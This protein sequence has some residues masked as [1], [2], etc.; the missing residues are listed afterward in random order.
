MKL[1]KATPRDLEEIFLLFK[2]VQKA[3]EE[4]GNR[5]WSEGYPDKSDFADDL[6]HKDAYLVKKEG[7][8]LAY[9]ASD[10]DLAGSFF[11]A[12]R[13]AGKLAV[14]LKQIHAEEGDVILSL[15][16][17]MVDPSFQGQGIAHEIFAAL[18]GLYP[19]SILV[20]AVFPENTRAIASYEHQGFHNLG[21]DPDFEYGGAECL[22]FY[23][24]KD[25]SKPE[26]GR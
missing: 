15:H 19:K 20:F 21:I 3:M 2:R 18:Q 25:S 24:K 12:T 11:P 13:S 6:R 4:E 7:R 8:I 14:L 22:L 26:S 16:R 9:I 17:L 5:S 23:R 10:N 1:E